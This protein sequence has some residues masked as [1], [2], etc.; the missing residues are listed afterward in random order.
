MTTPFSR[1]ATADNKLSWEG[2]YGTTVTSPIL[3]PVA[4]LL[5]PRDRCYHTVC[6]DS[7]MA[8]YTSSI[9]KHDCPASVWATITA[10]AATAPE[11]TGTNG[12]PA[13]TS[14]EAAADVLVPVIGVG[15]A[16]LTGVIAVLL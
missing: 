6:P 7:A 9:S 13:S 15:L 8:L 11:A 1:R 2:E 10:D 14:K 4:S 3:P 5:N 12:Q 16:W